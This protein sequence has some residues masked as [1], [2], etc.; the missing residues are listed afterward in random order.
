MSVQRP[1]RN[2]LKS[3]TNSAKATCC[4]ASDEEPEDM[5]WALKAGLLSFLL[6]AGAAGKD[7]AYHSMNL[8]SAYSKEFSLFMFGLYAVYSS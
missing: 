2:R 4:T 7:Y 1:L 3:F 8:R 6:V 5:N